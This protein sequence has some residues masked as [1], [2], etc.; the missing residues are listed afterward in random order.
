MFRAPAR[1]PVR[2][3]GGAS[4]S[5]FP[6]RIPSSNREAAP[7][8]GRG[9]ETTETSFAAR[10]SSPLSAGALLAVANF[11]LPLSS[12]LLCGRFARTENN[13]GWE[14]GGGAFG[15]GANK[16]FRGKRSGGF[17]CVILLPHRVTHIAVRAMRLDI[18]AT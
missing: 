15:R 13:L 12:L 9:S 3:A 11:C 14:G 8:Q 7:L 18:C 17:I 16:V 10:W 4:P 5:S 2:L 1:G 6:F